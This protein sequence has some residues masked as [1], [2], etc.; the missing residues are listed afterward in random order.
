MKVGRSP[1]FPCVNEALLGVHVLVV[2]CGDQHTSVITGS[3]GGVQF[4]QQLVS[5]ALTCRGARVL[6]ISADGV[7]ASLATRRELMQLHQPP[8]DIARKSRLGSGLM[9]APAHVRKAAMRAQ[10]QLSQRRSQSSAFAR[11]HARK[12]DKQKQGVA[13]AHVQRRPA[14]AAVRREA[15]RSANSSDEVSEAEGVDVSHVRHGNPR[16][17]RQRTRR[18]ASAR[19]AS[20]ARSSVNIELYQGRHDPDDELR[21]MYTAFLAERRQPRLPI[22]VAETERGDGLE[23]NSP[24]LAGMMVPHSRS[25]SRSAAVHDAQ[26]GSHLKARRPGS[27]VEPRVGVHPQPPMRPQSARYAAVALQHRTYAH[28]SGQPGTLPAPIAAQSPRPAST[29]LEQHLR[30]H[31]HEVQQDARRRHRPASATDRI[32]SPQQRSHQETA[33]AGQRRDGRVTVRPP[34]RTRPKR[35]TRPLSASSALRHSV[36]RD[37]GGS[38]DGVGTKPRRPVS[39]TTR[40]RRRGSSSKRIPRGPHGNQYQ[41]THQKPEAAATAARAP[42]G[43]RPVSAGVRRQGDMANGT[44]REGVQSDASSQAW[45]LEAAKE[46]NRYIARRRASGDGSITPWGGASVSLIPRKVVAVASTSRTSVGH[47]TNSHS[48]LSRSGESSNDTSSSEDEQEAEVRQ[49]SFVVPESAFGTGRPQVPV[50][51]LEPAEVEV[52]GPQVAGE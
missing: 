26:R 6:A 19:T 45:L 22:A 41:P 27:A 49:Q 16:A 1:T 18:P 7:Q 14:S 33:N 23:R 52:R 17:H 4:A 24:L 42:R 44:H 35:P 11:S 51:S 46:V 3:W 28:P 13:S 37:G 40:M 29:Q 9:F 8:G 31:K 2:S 32:E 30:R 12:R 21:D 50:A 5:A 36:G 25:V 47:V 39:A 20:K 38:A 34:P 48:Q 15:H 43:R 10:S